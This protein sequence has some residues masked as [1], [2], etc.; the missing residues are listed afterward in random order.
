MG[1]LVLHVPGGGMRDIKLDRDRITIGRRA[2]N[3]V[4]LQYPAVSAE[5]AEIVTVVGDSFLHDL[6]S[7]NGTLVNGA[8]IIKHFLLDGDRIDIGLIQLAYMADEAAPAEPLPLEAT[9]QPSNGVTNEVLIA[10]DASPGDADSEADEDRRNV[11][12]DSQRAAVDD[13]LAELMDSNSDTSVAVDMPPTI[14]VV[15]PLHRDRRRVRG[16][17]PDMTAGVFVEVMNGPNAGQIASMTRREF[18]LGKAGATK[19]VIRREADGFRLVPVDLSVTPT[20]ND[21]HVASEG[22]RLAFGDTIDVA[23]VKLRFGRRPPL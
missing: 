5:H 1:K 3:D 19:A 21:V 17:R 12:D 16:P 14:S 9:T 20:V 13:L 23:G 18:V 4:C 11:P 8:R 7:T 22:V 6:G 2:D 10:G 15:P